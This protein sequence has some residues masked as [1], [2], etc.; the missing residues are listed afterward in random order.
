MNTERKV[1]LFRTIIDW[2]VGNSPS[3]A[4]AYNTLNRDIGM[5]ENEIREEVSSMQDFIDESKNLRISAFIEYERNSVTLPLP[6]DIRNLSLK[7]SSIGCELNNPLLS[8][9]VYPLRIKLMTE[10][11][12]GC[13][14]ISLF[15]ESNSLMDV[16]K[17]IYRVMNSPDEIWPEL[18]KRLVASN[19]YTSFNELLR[20]I[21][22]MTYQFGEHLT[23]F[24]FPIVG[25]LVDGLSEEEEVSN[26]Y[27]KMFRR[28]IN[29]LLDKE[30][31]VDD[32]KQY[33][34][35]DDNTRNKIASVRYG[36][37][38]IKGILYGKVDFRL[39]EAFTEE[40]KEMIRDEVEGQ[41]S[42][43]FGE[44]LEDCPIE[45]EDGDLFISLWHS[46]D[47][48][49]ICEKDELWKYI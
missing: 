45:T 32:M 39:H 11:N 1:E 3:R 42:D 18:R 2:I 40:E 31:G 22:E 13:H 34:G 38:E 15:T 44:C 29:E 46:G 47:S 49:F 33:F 14:L 6:T 21:S 41:N 10:N 28:D 37:E 17:T 35:E 23:T 20:D 43:G 12:T 30:Q 19:K 26:R 25:K 7:L 16:S 9:P 48:Y 27:L 36:V 4:D 8:Y 5:T 24:Y